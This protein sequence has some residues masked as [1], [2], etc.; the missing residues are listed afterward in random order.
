MAN[1]YITQGKVE[2]E[3]LATNLITDAHSFENLEKNLAKTKAAVRVIDL[4]K[5]EEAHAKAPNTRRLLL[6][7]MARHHKVCIYIRCLP[8]VTS[9]ADAALYKFTLD[10]NGLEFWLAH[11]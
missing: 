8:A 11:A 4:Y 1:L 9:E 2:R 5:P 6:D 3:L 7:P 10:V